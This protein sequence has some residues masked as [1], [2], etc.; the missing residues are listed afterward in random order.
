MGQHFSVGDEVVVQFGQWK[1]RHGWV[2][3]LQPAC[4]YR[5]EIAGMKAPLFFGEQSLLSAAENQESLGQRPAARTPQWEAALS[6]GNRRR[7]L[8]RPI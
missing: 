4:I 7:S 2:M 3:Q 5:V 6:K 1:G 8:H